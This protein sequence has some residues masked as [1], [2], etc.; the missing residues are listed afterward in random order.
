LRP[1]N[2]TPESVLDFWFGN[3]LESPES[4]AA[5]RADWFGK[6][7][8][9][10]ERIRERFGELPSRA[11]LGELGTWRKAARPSLALVLILDQFPRNLYRGSPQSFA[12]DALAREVAEAAIASRFDAVLA[13]LEALFIYLPLEHAEE[14]AAQDRA[15]ALC[16]ALV[17]RA[18][19]GQ[20]QQFKSFLS[21]SIRHREVIRR[22]GRFPHRNAV[23][24]RHSTA[25]ELSYLDSGGESF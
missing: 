21:Y 5:R 14:M 22:F 20:R 8:A 10:D 4:T 9:F 3:A 25:E 16:E 1:V 11:L 6:D 18:P 13:P 2:A 7:P 15:V 12:C 24:G 17:K 19:A 23:L